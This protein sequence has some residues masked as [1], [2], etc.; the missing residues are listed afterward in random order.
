M[1][2]KF[3]EFRAGWKVVAAASLGVGI[4]VSGAPFY[5]IGVFLKP[6]VA[7]FGWSRAAVAAAT[8]FLA[9]GHSLTA[10]FVGRLADRIDVRKIA[11]FSMAA[12]ILGYLGLTRVSHNVLSLYFWLGIMAIVG[13]GTTP[14]VWT[15]VVST[16]FDRKRGLALGLTLAGSGIAALVAP[17][18]VDKLIQ[19]YGWQ[20]GYIG[21]ALFAA[22]VGFPVVFL[23]FRENKGVKVNDPGIVDARRGP[24]VS[25]AVRSVRFWQLAVGI[26][27][28]GGSVA[29]ILIHLV[30]LMTDSG[31]SRDRATAV[32]GLL[33][34]AVV[35]GRIGIGSLVDRFHA[36]YVAGI[37]LM[38]PVIGYLL[39]A[40]SHGDGWRLVVATL[41][42]GLSAGAE[43][44]LLAYLTGRFFGLRAFGSIYGLL[45]VPFGVAAGIGPILLGRVYDVTGSYGP[46]LYTGALTCG[47]GALLIASLGRYPETFSEPATPHMG[48]GARLAGQA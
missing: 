24:A 32:A 37:V 45:L 35:F 27:L 8:L 40:N 48:D 47:I 1:D 38:A 2:H 16:W 36:P 22:I 14:L 4:G 26:F 12:L 42:F 43:V 28:V 41:L 6:L 21:L 7:E 39:T 15:H 11:L 17:R 46:G 30:P 13:C 5:T 44:D 31:M 3:S 25:E 9:T 33:G 18:A 19:Y 34:F 20:A 10:P 23:F 29:A